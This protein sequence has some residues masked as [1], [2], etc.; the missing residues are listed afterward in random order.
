MPQCFELL[1]GRPK[2]VRKPTA[3]KCVSGDEYERAD[4]VEKACRVRKISSEERQR[5]HAQEAEDVEGRH[6]KP[7]STEPR[8]TRRYVGL[9]RV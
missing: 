2:E 3:G 9:G 7:D 1:R 4:I 5:V 6:D 8:E